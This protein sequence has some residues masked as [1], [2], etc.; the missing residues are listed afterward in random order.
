MLAQLTSITPVVDLDTGG[1][2]ALR[3]PPDAIDAAR[4]EG[5]L[6]LLLDLPVRVVLNGSGALAPLHEALRR[7]GRRPREVILVLRGGCGE[8][9]RRL[10]TVGLDGLRAIG[11]LLAFGGLGA[12]SMPPDLIADASP[13]LLCLSTDVVGRAPRDPRRAA[14]ARSVVTMARGIGAHVL[15]PGVEDEPQ[16]GQVRDWGVRLAEGPLLAPGR[17]GRVH[18]PLPTPPQEPNAALLG[19]RVQELLLPAVTLPEQATAEE[20]I[21]AFGTEPSITSVILVDDYQRPKGSLD[22]GRFLLSFSSRFGH[23]LHG[24]KPALRL[25]DPPRA[26]PKTTPAIAAMQVAGRDSTRAYDDLVVTD[27]VNRCMGIVRVSD[28]MRR[29]SAARAS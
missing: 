9:E 5:M 28:L 18:V 25:A 2:V 19:P 23:A 22:R 10:L 13:Y 11:Y 29:V 8:A 20:V 3:T 27:E 21:E 16:L 15:A 4:R 24:R 12:E 26:V 7:S 6:P 14:V 1:V 17:D